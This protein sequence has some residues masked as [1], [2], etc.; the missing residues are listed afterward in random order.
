MDETLFIIYD[1]KADFEKDQESINARSLVFIKDTREVYTHGIFFTDQATV[2]AVIKQIQTALTGKLTNLVANDNS[3]TV[4]STG[5]ERGIKVKVVSGGGLAVGAQGLSVDTGVIA[6]KVSVDTLNSNL[7]TL[8][9]NV[10]KKSET[11]TQK[12]V[13]DRISQVTGSVYNVRGSVATYAD[14]PAASEASIGDVYNIMTDF[15]H[16]GAPYPAGTNVVLANYREGDTTVVD[17][18]PLG[19]TVDLSGYV[20][21]TRTI[22]GNALSGNVILNGA[23]LKMTGYTLPSSYSAIAV[24]DTIN[25]AMGKVERLATNANGAATATGNYTVNTKKISTNPVL[26]GADLKLT[27]YTVASAYAA[28]AATDTVNQAI[29][30]LAKGVV[31]QSSSITM[32]GNYTINGKKI[33]TNPVLKSGDIALS[34]YTTPAGGV[35]LP[36]DTLNSAI[37]KLDT[38]LSIITWKEIP[39]SK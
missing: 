21:V 28:P 38:A 18:D 19:G 12:E 35:V 27:G 34:G 13:N 5:T 33:S 22:N 29:G 1:L 26:N 30:K 6:S 4:T 15:T 31:D 20:P 37:S 24:G 10:Y 16:N 36:A 3:V 9:N 2:D 11:Y 23:S 14:L 32:L 39:A 8:S 7:T 25:A 17:W